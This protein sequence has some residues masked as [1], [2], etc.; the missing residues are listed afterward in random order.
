MAGHKAGWD[1]WE[2]D[3]DSPTSSPGA[4]R[5]PWKK[6]RG[7][8]GTRNRK[9]PQGNQAHNSL[10]AKIQGF[11]NCITESRGGPRALSKPVLQAETTCLKEHN[12]VYLNR[13]PAFPHSAYVLV[14]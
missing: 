14:C 1:E 4:S 10:E 11:V 13:I 2:W 5:F 12:I 8:L 9:S 7:A 3:E 6:K